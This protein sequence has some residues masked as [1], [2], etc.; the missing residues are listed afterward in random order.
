[1]NRPKRR[2]VPMKLQRNAAL[3]LC[4]ELMVKLGL[5]QV[6]AWQLDHDPALGLRP[7][8]DA[9]TDYEPAQHDPRFLVWRPIRQHAEKT[10]GRALGTSRHAR[11]VEGDKQRIA[12][13]K[14]LEEKRQATSPELDRA[15][16]VLLKPRPRRQVYNAR[17]YAC[18]TCG[19]AGQVFAPP[20]APT[21]CATCGGDG[22]GDERPKRPWPKRKV[23]P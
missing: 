14:R 3:A 13:A 1:M 9:G 12:K 16:E 10:N 7:V 18:G 21:T 23:R 22:K 17:Y 5:E 20:A 15:L 2:A 11:R 6:D 19:G 4:A 8:N